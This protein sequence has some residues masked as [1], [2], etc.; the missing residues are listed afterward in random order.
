MI[1]SGASFT[2]PTVTPRARYA[3]IP[4]FG[5]RHL[6]FG[7]RPTLGR[8]STVAMISPTIYVVYHRVRRR[9][10]IT[11]SLL[12]AE[13]CI[14]HTSIT[15]TMSKLGIIATT[16]TDLRRTFIALE[17]LVSFVPWNFSNETTWSRLSISE[18]RSFRI[19]IEILN[20]ED[21]PG[22]LLPSQS[23]A[24]RSA[25][26]LAFLPSSDLTLQCQMIHVQR[27]RRPALPDGIEFVKVCQPRTMRFLEL[28]GTALLQATYEVTVDEPFV[29]HSGRWAR[30]I[31]L[32]GPNKSAPRASQRRGFP[33]HKIPTGPRDHPGSNTY[34]VQRSRLDGLFHTWP[35]S[36]LGY[37]YR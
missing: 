36:N 4:R 22:L 23:C 1:Q 35:L 5:S 7:N 17:L 14:T 11:C 30:P 24:L 37:Q 10:R 21:P 18:M 8:P 31:D 34:N 27:H 15:S 20:G 19:Q 16:T 3:V 25:T 26:H 6:A 28:L 9:R 12:S 33:Y 29:R 13:H 2:Q 32:A